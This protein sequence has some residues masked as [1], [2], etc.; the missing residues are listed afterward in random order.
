M[1]VDRRV[2]DGLVASWMLLTAVDGGRWGG[3]QR[4]FLSLTPTKIV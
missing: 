4:V 1:R 3:H 2:S